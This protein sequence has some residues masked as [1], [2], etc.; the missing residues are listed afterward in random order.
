MS[1]QSSNGWTRFWFEPAQASELNW[2]RIGLC[3]V[4]TV[5]FASA[6]S[7]VPLWF[8]KDR[9]A[10]TTNLGIFFRTA[11]LNSDA[12]WMFSPLFLFDSVTQGTA[13]SESALVYRAYLAIGIALGL[14]AATGG[15]LAR[16]LPRGLLANLL[17]GSLPVLL[18]WVWLVGWANRIVLIAGICEPVLS[19]SLAALAIAPAVTSE[20]SWRVGLAK[21]LIAVQTTLIVLV[22]LAS[23]L[24]GNVWWNGT[25]AYALVAP[26]E[27]RFVSVA[28][29]F[30]EDAAAFEATTFVLILALPIALWLLRR[31]SFRGTG[32]AV[33]W[34]WC[35]IVALLSA[36]MLYSVTLSV[37]VLSINKKSHTSE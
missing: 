18:L 30:F 2:V 10:S 12:R 27:D 24:F 15:G 37:L 4:A 25:G 9:A 6:W 26:A 34:M 14:V 11:E 23:M 29:T 1:S 31:E 19:V 28:G 16:R 35:A 22:T 32:V 3:L 5:Y 33:W 21:R 17:G 36:E 8:A 7:D 13:W 20:P